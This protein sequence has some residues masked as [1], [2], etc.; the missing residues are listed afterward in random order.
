MTMNF[1]IYFNESI[2]QKGPEY[3]TLRYTIKHLKQG[4]SLV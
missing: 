4:T 2:K 3:R 1:D